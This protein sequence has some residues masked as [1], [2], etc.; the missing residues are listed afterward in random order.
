MSTHGHNSAVIIVVGFDHSLYVFEDSMWI[1]VPVFCDS[2]IQIVPRTGVLIVVVLVLT[3]LLS[4]GFMDVFTDR[5]KHFAFDDDMDRFFGRL[6]QL[7]ENQGLDDVIFRL[8]DADTILSSL[9]QMPCPAIATI[10]RT[11]VATYP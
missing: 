10:P 9:D 4:N 7:K 1:R 2:D 3:L 6:V 5:K 11:G 8:S